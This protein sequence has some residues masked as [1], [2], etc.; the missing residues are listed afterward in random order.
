MSNNTN[1]WVDFPAYFRALWGYEPFP[2]QTML[3]R[4]V[5]AEEWPKA[6]D[7]PTA[8]GK[9][10]CIDA[11]VYALAMQADTP[12]WERT[13]PRRIWFV[14]DRRIVVDEAF[15]RS[16]KMAKRLRE[17]TEGPLKMVA[18]RLRQVGGTERPLAVARLRGGVLRD[19][20]WARLPSQPAVITSTVDQLGSRLLFRGY[21]HSALTAPIFAGLAVHDSVILLDEAHLSFPFLQTLQ[22][23][24]LY[25]GEKWAELPLRTPFGFCFLSA[26]LPAAVPPNAVFPG[27][28]RKVALDHPE[29]ARRMSVSKPAELVTVR[30]ARTSDKDTFVE[31]AA[32]RTISFVKTHGKQR[33]AVVVNRVHTA[34]SIAQTLKARHHHDFDV[35]L[36][37][38][39]LRPFERDSLIARWKP[40]LEASQP[41]PPERPV[42][43]VATQCIEVGA[44]FSFDAL[45][46]EAAGLDALRQRF[47]RLN[48]MGRLEDSP[49]VILIRAEDTKPKAEDFIYGGALNRT[50]QL[51]ETLATT[52]GEANSARKFVDFGTAALDTQ[53]ENVDDLSLYLAPVPTAPLLLPAHVDLL[54]QTAPQSAVEPDIQFYLHGI[55][56]GI[57]EVR[58]CWRSDLDDAERNKDTCWPEIIA[59]CPPNSAETLSVPLTRLQKWLA[60][61]SGNDDGTEVEGIVGAEEPIPEAIRPV[62][63]WRGRQRSRLATRA[64][65]IKP[66]EVV[67]LPA[68]YGIEGLGQA[69]PQQALGEAQ[70]DIWE[71]THAQSGKPVALRLQ[72]QVLRPWLACPPVKSLLER[73]EDPCWDRDTVREAIDSLL[74]YEPSAED[75]AVH[76]PNWLRTLLGEVRDG[77]YEQHPA[78][79][80][81]LFSRK[82]GT[83]EETEVD[84]FADDDDVLSAAGKEVS[85]AIHS[86][87][88]ERAV[89][90]LARHCVPEAFHPVLKTAGYWHDVGKADERFQIMLRQGNELAI[91]DEPLAKSEAIPDSPF[92][93]RTIRAA[94]GLPAD[95]RH[96]MVSL[97]LV[98]HRFPNAATAA[99][100]NLLLH[101]IGSHHGHGR[102]F[103]PVCPDPNPPPIRHSV[104]GTTL[105]A[106]ST[107]RTLWPPPY[108]LSSGISER[109][110]SLIR[111]YG[112]WGLAYLE[113]ILRL[114]D[115]YGSR[116]IVNEE[117]KQAIPTA[118]S[119]ILGTDRRDKMLGDNLRE[120]RALTLA[121]LDGVNPLGFLAALGTLVVLHQ[122]G[123]R[124]SRLAWQRERLAWHPRLT[125]LLTDDASELAKLLAE[126]LG[127]KPVSEESEEKVKEAENRFSAMNKTINDKRNEIKARGLR[128]KERN[129]ALEAEVGPLERELD[130][131]RKEWLE[132]LQES[133]SRPEL[134][135]GRNIDCT[136]SEYRALVEPLLEGADAE[137]RESL[138]MLAAFCS[139]GCLHESPP[140]RKQGK[141]APTPFAFISGSGH[142]DFLGTAGEL[143]KNVSP[144]RIEAALFAPWTYEEERLSMRWDPVEDRRYALMDRDPT[145]GDNQPRTVWMA[146]LL[147]YRALSLFPSVPTRHG[148]ATVGWTRQEE[149][150]FTWPLW[151][152]PIDPDSIRSLLVLPEL[153]NISSDSRNRGALWA[154]GIQAVY[155]SRRIRVGTGANFKI[156]FTPSRQL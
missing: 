35:V 132:A 58:V 14:V 65:D 37:T 116:W 44:D 13:A 4:R 154:R 79:G 60:G 27:A 55:D 49:A 136:D 98:E 31:E 112:W 88:V 74:A 84:L 128:G 110:W 68:S 108:A 107:E 2:W 21:G 22:A 142:Q 16:R 114:G 29:L 99:L 69:V 100:H 131:L 61:R 106:S 28:Q 129:Q 3:A 40:V 122:S 32:N 64:V 94:A 141:L 150:V 156:N 81:I 26:T 12:P 6:L 70:L 23:V 104:D 93:R 151:E 78:G 30:S 127:G 115:W 153:R 39:R 80:L 119:V 11:A 105:E 10:A 144:K 67:V 48:R 111:T 86:A 57:P 36:L 140:K 120:G 95:F 91:L 124:S 137:H 76:P 103:A 50:W 130:R 5:A 135:L 18:D 133:V 149:P 43:L 118:P 59:L 52:E 9:T 147:A 62:L 38:G 121:G 63:L 51:L 113:A 24:E 102:P 7:L 77:R 15:E 71:P 90:K 87:A 73:A 25:R 125:G 75:E 34:E 8:A 72:R 138:D 33:V 19:D 42:V 45:V 155:R 20:G 92:R 1:D 41:I 89:E 146:N 143:L 96:E 134:A 47:G 53:L 117:G 46:T 66:E 54:C 145:A 17:A 152:H 123:C 97:Q 101:T 148:L 85:L 82:V 139:A 56:R 126:N 83:Q 109:F